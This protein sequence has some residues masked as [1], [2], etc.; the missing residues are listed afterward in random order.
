MGF[1]F[2]L[3]KAKAKAEWLE[4]RV[5]GAQQCEQRLVQLHSCIN[6]IDAELCASLEQD[7]YADELPEL[8]QVNLHFPLKTAYIGHFV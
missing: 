2:L 5:R 3:I 8:C 1:W 6:S 4:N 7:L